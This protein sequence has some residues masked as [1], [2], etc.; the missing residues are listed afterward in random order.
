MK[1]IP[2]KQETKDYIRYIRESYARP[3]ETSKENP[4]SAILLG[5][6]VLWLLLML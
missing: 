1:V 6:V 3:I 5:A 4:D 2:T